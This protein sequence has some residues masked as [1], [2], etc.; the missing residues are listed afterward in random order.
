MMVPSVLQI[1]TP[2]AGEARKS[3][4]S[5]SK[6]TL[7]CLAPY[8]MRKV[9]N[10]TLLNRRPPA[11]SSPPRIIFQEFPRCVPPFVS[12][13]R[14]FVLPWKYVC[15]ARLCQPCSM[16]GTAVPRDSFMVSGCAVG[17]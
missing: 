14:S 4:A 15:V 17:T 11:M 13:C 3:S 6:L 5:N 8:A 7:S 1:R 9:L 10:Q 2:Y 12:L 16:A